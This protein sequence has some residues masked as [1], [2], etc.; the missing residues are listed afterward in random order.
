MQLPIL[1]IFLFG[2][3]TIINIPLVDCVGDNTNSEFISISH[4]PIFAIL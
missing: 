1:H 4:Q 2:L 3:I